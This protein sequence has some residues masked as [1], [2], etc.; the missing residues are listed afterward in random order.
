MPPAAAKPVVYAMQAGRAAAQP[1]EAEAEAEPPGMDTQRLAFSERPDHN[2]SKMQRRRPV[3]SHISDKTFFRPKLP[4]CLNQLTGLAH[5]TQPETSGSTCKSPESR[6]DPA[7]IRPAMR[8][9]ENINRSCTAQALSLRLVRPTK[10]E[11]LSCEFISAPPQR[12]SE[13]RSPH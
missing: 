12:F 6:S 4:A 8:I 3:A 5:A 1:A 11:E 10:R 2:W 9:R 13:P 7:T